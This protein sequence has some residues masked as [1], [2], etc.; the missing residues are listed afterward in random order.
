ML[1]R[2]INISLKGL[3]KYKMRTFLMMLGIIIGIA[4][5]TVI[6]SVSKGMQK[7]VMKSIQSFGSNAV[8][9]SAGGGKMFGPPDEKVTSLTLDDA[10]AIREQV[11]GIRA[12]S[13]FTMALEQTVIYGSKN[14]MSPVVG[15]TPEFADA[16]QWYAEKGDF[17]SDEDNSSMSKNCMLGQTVVSELFGDQDPVGETI[18]VNNTN[19]KIIG[20]LSKRGTSPRGMDM[21]RRVMVPLTTAMK[22]LY[23]VT[24]IG[25]IRLYIDDSSR[26]DEVS[27]TVASILKERHHITPPQEDDFRVTNTMA[28]ANMA[29]GVS[30][31]L[32]TFLA[33]LSLISLAVGGIVIANIMF[34]SVNERKKEIGIRRAFGATAVDIRKQFLGEALFVTIGGGIVGTA[35][36]IIV[37]EGLA[38]I[39]KMPVVI[40]WEPFAL[41]IVFSTLVGIIAGLQPAKRAAA[42][43]PVDAIR[44]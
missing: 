25:M 19:F 36:G 28:M 18:R 5:L 15:V 34:I 42:M 2:V 33:L 29:K 20:V 17:I 31:T 43:D 35:L 11:K 38:T 24:Y 27:K 32:G 12:M 30:K 41:A 1:S 4:T 37:S 22:R 23:N 3:S 16:W 8:M 44:G 14:T 26:L 6:V 9:V 13:P 40:S 21:D 39:K 10:D 7:K